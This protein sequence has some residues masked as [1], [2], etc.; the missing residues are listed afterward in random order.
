MNLW[1][2]DQRIDPTSCLDLDGFVFFMC[3]PPQK[4]KES[5]GDYK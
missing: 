3:P 4:K 2:S 1:F 5:G